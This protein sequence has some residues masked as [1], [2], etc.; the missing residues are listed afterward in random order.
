MNLSYFLPTR[1]LFGRGCLNDIG[2]YG[3][4]G[5][6][7]LLVISKGKSMKTLGYV[8]RVTNLLVKNGAE[9]VLFDD[10]K[11]NPEIENVMDGKRT[12][13]ENGCDFV[14]GLGG[15]STIDCAKSIAVMCKNE[16]CVWDYI[17]GTA[18]GTKRTAAGALPVIAIPTTAGT[19]TEA[20]PWTVITNVETAEKRGFGGVYTF[21]VLA[22]VDPELMASVPKILTAYQGFDAL[23]HCMEAYYG[24]AGNKLSNSFAEMGIEDAGRFLSRAVRDGTDM[25][26]R[27]GMAYASLMGGFTLSTCGTSAMHAISQGMGGY[28]HD[29][30]HGAALILICEAFFT[31]Y[32]QKGVSS[33]IDMG[34]MLGENVDALPLNERPMST[35]YALRRLRKE[36]GVD[37]IKMSDWGLAPKYFEAIA[38]KSIK[39]SPV[40]FKRDPIVL[41]KEEVVQILND[42][43]EKCCFTIA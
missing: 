16:G 3:I 17:G 30:P 37:K 2:Q 28:A 4:P 41:S 33:L 42:S 21:P 40:L 6:K 15:G 19:G 8:D 9:V 10:V 26:A 29:L 12:A 34:R 5:K 1:I 7:A 31:Y 18:D 38:E 36:C 20:D 22:V 32:A 25:E 39:N 13:L 23:F 35:I 27:E 24:V 14:V 43:Y 11:P